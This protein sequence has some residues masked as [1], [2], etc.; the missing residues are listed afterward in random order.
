M[1][2]RAGAEAHVLMV[3]SARLYSVD[4]HL[5]DEVLGLT[6]APV[7]ADIAATKPA[8]EPLKLSGPED[9][10]VAVLVLHGSQSAPE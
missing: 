9:A 2:A 5:A 4:S 10:A 1:R 6:G 8:D 7:V 3:E